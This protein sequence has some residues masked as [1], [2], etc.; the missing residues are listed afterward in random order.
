MVLTTPKIPEE[1]PSL[2]EFLKSTY[3]LLALNKFRERFISID[4]FPLWRRH[5]VWAKKSGEKLRDHMTQRFATNMVFMGLFLTTELGVLFSPCDISTE[6][7]DTL[8][9]ENGHKKLI[10]Y[11]GVFLIFSVFL[12]FFALLATFTAWAIISSISD[13]N[14]HCILRSSIGITAAQLPSRLVAA[15]IY[16]FFV[17][18]M[19]LM[20]VLTPPKETQW[21]W[22]T[23]TVLSCTI[24]LYIVNIYSALGNLI[25]KSSAMRNKRVFPREEEEKKFPFQLQEALLD[26]AREWEKMGIKV[27]V[28]YRIDGDS[29]RT[30]EIEK[31]IL[32]FAQD[33]SLETTSNL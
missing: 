20:W 26:K 4:H 17:W 15:S 3:S 13:S 2:C 32:D 9:M 11:A 5:L 19:L 1:T 31:E 10:F 30:S 23:I 8:Q 29:M 25:L 33:P 6:L 28:Q 12:T 27:T 24:F 21:I 18:N 16:T 14:S 7:R 22:I